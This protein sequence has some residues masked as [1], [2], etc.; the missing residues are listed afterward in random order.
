MMKTLSMLLI[1]LLSTLCG[2][3]SEQTGNTKRPVRP[4]D[5]LSIREASDVRLSPSGKSVVF[6]LTSIDPHTHKEF[7]NL[8]LSL[9]GGTP[10]QLT[11]GQYNDTL[12]RWAP[13]G[14]RLA[15]ASSRDGESAIWI[16]DSQ[17]RTIRK[18]AP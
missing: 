4:D 7:S 8:W 10:V 15:F 14:R 3:S 9:E 11:E 6:V 18:L 16:A 17:T 1:L 5:L 13:D 2:I 12:P